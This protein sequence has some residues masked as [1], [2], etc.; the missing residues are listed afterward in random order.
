MLE[1]GIKP[2]TS[3]INF[4]VINKII[5]RVYGK[6]YTH[7][8]CIAKYIKLSHMKKTQTNPLWTY[9]QMLCVQP[10][11]TNTTT[12]KHELRCREQVGNWQRWRWGLVKLVKV[13]KCIDTSH[14]VNEHWEWNYSMVTQVNN[15]ILYT[16]NLL[17]E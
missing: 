14:K 6:W 17:K 8:I 12:W 16:W 4:Y 15:N 1:L 11:T 3:Y 10:T 5:Y 13:V 7:D 2:K 9:R